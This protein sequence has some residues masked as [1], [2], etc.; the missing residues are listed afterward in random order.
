MGPLPFVPRERAL[1]ELADAPASLEFRAIALDPRAVVYRSG[2]GLLLADRHG[3]LIG[4]AGAVTARDFE[5]LDEIKELDCELLAD[6]AAYQVLRAHREFE[7]AIIHTLWGS[8]QRPD[9][10][11][12]GLVVRPL[13]RSDSLD[14]LPRGLRDEIERARQREIVFA[15]FIEGAAVSFSY[16]SSATETLAD[17]SIDTLLAHRGRGVG[18]AVASTLIDC[19]VRQGKMPVWGAAEDNRASLRL[20]E[21][22]GFTRPAGELFVCEPRRSAGEAGG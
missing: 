11:I 15:G 6:R 19:L 12:A 20:A 5:A 1:R 17:V 9:L 13:Q 3:P 22:L 7:R 4:A 8:W 10:Q 2:D 16:S 18:A 21:K 14:R